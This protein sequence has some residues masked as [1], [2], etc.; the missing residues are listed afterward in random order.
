MTNTTRTVKLLLSRIGLDEYRFALEPRGTQTL[1]RIEYAASDGW[2]S[3][4]FMVDDADLA[5]SRR[6]RRARDGLLRDWC[7]R[8]IRAKRRADVAEDLRAEATAL[9]RAWA[10]Q[11]A[12]ELRDGASPAEWPDFWDEAENGALPPDLD[13]AQLE[14]MSLA[15]SR[16][17]RERWRELVREERAQA[18]LVEEQDRELITA[19]TRPGA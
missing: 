3:T 10:E 15:A 11:K 7:N 19:K 8:L 14:E 12:E 9:G 4:N 1:V 6:D 18:D 5:A 17:A 2:R 13:A 16:A